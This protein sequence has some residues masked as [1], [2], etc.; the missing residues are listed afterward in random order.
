MAKAIASSSKLNFGRRKKGS[1]KK[2]Y[3]KHSP[4]PKEYRGQGKL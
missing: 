2:A 1:V 4:R 3:N